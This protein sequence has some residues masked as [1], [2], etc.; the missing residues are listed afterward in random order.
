[1]FLRYPFVQQSGIM[2]CGAASLLMIVRYYKGWVSLAK[3]QELTN[4]NQSGTT[5]FHLVKAAK[6]IGFQAKGI[7]SDLAALTKIKPPIIA[8]VTVAKTY[9]HYL[10]IYK[11]NVKK[12][13]LII[14]DPAEKIKKMTFNDFNA[15]WNNVLIVLTPEKQLP[16]FINHKKITLQ[17]LWQVIK[18]EVKYLIP[19]A[20]LT[21]LFSIINTYYFKFIIDSLVAKS[22]NNYIFL[23]FM[24]FLFLN[25]LYLITNYFKNKILIYMKLKLDAALS[26]HTFEKIISLP[27]KYYCSH[28]TGEIVSRIN[29]LNVLKNMLTSL[30]MPIFIDLPITLL[31]IYFLYSLSP[32][33]FSIAMVMYLLFL[34]ILFAFR[35]SYQ[36]DVNKI[37][38][39]KGVLNSLLVQYINSYE[40]IKGLAIEKKINHNLKS[41]QAK[42]LNQNKKFDD[43]QNT[44][45][46]LTKIVSGIGFLIIIYVGAL[47]V[48]EEQMTIGALLTFHMLLIYFFE[49]VKNLLELDINYYEMKNALRRIVDLFT[50]EKEVDGFVKKEPQ[51]TIVINNLSYSYDRVTNVLKNLSLEIKKGEKILFFGQSGSGKSTLLKL[52]MRYYP[53]KQNQ[54]LFDGIDIN[55]FQKKNFQ[56]QIV[57]ISQKENLFNTT[58]YQNLVL[59]NKKD[60]G[61]IIEMCQIK[62]FLDINLGL[63]MLVEEN[64]F[65]L[66]GGQRQRLVLARSLIKKANI[67]LIDEGFS[68]LDVQ[69]ER[70]ILQAIFKFFK[71]TTFIVITHRLDNQDLYD[72]C[73][74]LKQ[75]QL[76]EAPGT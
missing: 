69:L 65:N 12:K 62:E 28:T 55:D 40:T 22:Q 57:Y 27:Y 16:K 9:Q 10:V 39:Q 31:A 42:L 72:K 52:M 38:V 63:N 30:L 51:G 3:M 33:L 41:E 64:S 71:K 32:T 43:L 45:N 20:L 66:S 54:I 7:K 29:D 49:P 47:L 4:T 13:Q 11:I 26:F 15:I 1:M 17:N 37:Q 5:A 23:I 75:G 73:Y 68:E 70:K 35:G 36:T 24:S 59:V 50:D 21:T 8:H 60:L 2:D 58:I 19:L 46:I 18:E 61:K 34:I 14:A 44:Q 53:V 67:V 25:S 48:L 6:E 76:H 74:F 56:Q